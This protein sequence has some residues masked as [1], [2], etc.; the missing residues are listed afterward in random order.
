MTAR[1]RLGELSLRTRVT[2]LVSVAVGL[3]VALTSVAAYLT[4]RH[5]LYQGLDR[6]LVLRA[7][8]AAAS[9]LSDPV[10]LAQVP[11]AALGS[12]DVRIAV[13]TA[14]GHAVSAEGQASAPPLGEPELAVARGESALS[15]RTA[16]LDG[17]DYRVVA[18]PT[19]PGTALVLAQS[20]AGI[21]EELASIGVVLLVVGLVGIAVA[22]SAGL[23]V[24]RSAL[25]PVE[26]LTTAAEHVARTED[27]RPIEVHGD[28]ELARLARS[29]NAMLAALDQSRQRQQQLVADAG[30][31]LR[32]PLTSM[33]TNLDL[34]A[35]SL[36][37]AAGL[38]P[39]DR[40]EL[41][42]DVRAQVEEMSDLV[43]DLVELARTEPAPAPAEHV[44]LAAVV[45]R[46][47]ERVRRRAPRVRFAAQLTPWELAGD[48]AMLERAITN[49][50][51]NA[52]GWSADGGSVTVTLA[53]GVLQVAD[54][55]P[56]IAEQDLP[57]VFERFYRSAEARGRPGSGLGLAIVRQAVERHGGSVTAGRAPSGGALLTVRLPG[58]RPASQAVPS[59]G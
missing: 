35:Q 25:R 37:S 26:R 3:A 49:L 50:L 39:A 58:R 14:G 2:L 48:P 22:A 45:E 19:R 18:A 8:A 7:Q 56:G 47:L 46:A 16:E 5:E 30:H 28:D 59:A 15:L 44:D 9:S 27:L 51:D 21:R 42:A 31:E 20:T 40:A 38:S 12:A 53:D 36:R 10:R 1:P 24:A 17:E 29:F 43:A 57:Y 11:A 33:R 4:A 52:A 13:V 41:L 54:S 55:G 34:L 23:A 6:N 32:T